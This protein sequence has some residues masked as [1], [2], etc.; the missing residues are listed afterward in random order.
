M[1]AFVRFVMVGGSF[2]LIYAATT[3]GLIRF[4]A[5]PPFAAS[6]LVYLLCIPPAFW[7]QRHFAFRAEKSGRGRFWIYG[8]TQI[9]SLTLITSVA[10]HFVTQNFWKDTFIF[11]VTAAAAAI[12]SFAICRNIIF[13]NTSTTGTR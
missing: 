13:K 11:L 5:T 4:T 7:A 9:A 3:A 1:I 2:S 6:I 12:I 8:T 10:T